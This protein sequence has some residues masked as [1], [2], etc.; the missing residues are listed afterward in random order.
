MKKQIITLAIAVALA[1]TNI[2]AYAAEIP[3][4]STPLNA[5][6]QQI[7][8]VEN[9][10]GDILDEIQAG[11]IGYTLAAGDANTRI[12]KAV[13][14]NETDGNGYGILSPIARNAIRVMRDMQLRSD[15]WIL[16]ICMIP[17]FYIYWFIILL[18]F[19]ELSE[20]Q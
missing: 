10:I 4:E 14:A 1:K 19:G 12:R 8:I 20:R 9:L 2:S 3:R 11:N 13:M 16:L 6:E 7:Q 17:L 18:D 5:T 15:A